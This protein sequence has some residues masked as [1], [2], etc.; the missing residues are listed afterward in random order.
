MKKFTGASVQNI[1][2]KKQSDVIIQKVLSDYGTVTFPEDTEVLQTGQVLVT[3]DGGQTF[4]VAAVDAKP[5]AILCE[6]ITATTKAE[7]LLIGT[8]REKYLEGLSDEHKTALFENKII[9]R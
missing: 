8:V 5:N 7:V 1:T 4:D 9:L 3:A 6:S 2:L